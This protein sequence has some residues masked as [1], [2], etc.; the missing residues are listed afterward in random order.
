MRAKAQDDLLLVPL[1]VSVVNATI[2]EE[3]VDAMAIKEVVHMA[4]LG[5]RS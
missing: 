3:I 1:Q 4:A 2:L 5:C